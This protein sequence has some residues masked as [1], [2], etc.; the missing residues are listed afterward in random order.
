MI[1]WMKRI[2]AYFTR[3]ELHIGTRISNIVLLL[4]GIVII[5]CIV[6][7]V[8][9]KTSTDGIVAEII[10]LFTIPFL[11]WYINSKRRGQFPIA[12]AMLCLNAIIFPMLFFACGGRTTGMLFWMLLGAL[13]SAF[14]LTGWY[15]IAA[16]IINSIVIIVCLAYQY[17]CPEK[18]AFIESG[19][20][21]L[22]IVAAYC[23]V[24]II[25][26]FA[27]NVQT[28]V[29]DKQ[30]KLLEEKEAELE[31]L[32][33]ELE[34]VSRAKSD[35]LA[36]MSH[37]IRT[38]INAVLGMDEMIIRDAIDPVVLNYAKDIDVAGKQLLSVINDILD[39]SKIEAGK[40]DVVPAEYSIAN[41]VSDCIKIQQ[42]RATDKKLEIK[43]D[44]DADI[45]KTLLGDENR[46]KQ[47]L[48]NIISNAIKY[49]HKGYVKLIVGYEDEPDGDILLKCSVEDSGIGISDEKKPFVFSDYA[50]LENNKN[51]EGTGL[52]LAISKKLVELMGGSI[53]FDSVY[54]TGSTFYF[55]IPQKVLDR[56]PCG[57]F[58][59][60]NSKTHSGKKAYRQSFTAENANVLVVDDV[61]VNLNV[62][63]LL[64][65][66]TKMKIDL[67]ESGAEAL[68]YLGRNH[69]DVVL[70]DHIMPDM[71]GVETLNRI[72]ELDSDNR[73][74]PVI[75]LT[76]N[77]LTGADTFYY[78]AGFCA[79]LTKPVKVNELEKS[80]LKHLPAELVDITQKP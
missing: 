61:L 76:A 2:F 6:L 51:I 28:K 10:L 65:R 59:L 16:Y 48:L 58:S 25:I 53:G 17:Y 36:N 38:P 52:G 73:N 31:R 62:V 5:P 20:E 15:K 27:F 55:A 78:D 66:D 60:D 42:S 79:Y 41:A 37:E 33:T 56:E 13:F 3:E 69:Y 35:F 18:I 12:M 21:N 45:P 67:A 44:F 70:M 46:V 68:E 50:R 71:D 43:V 34:R 49:T 26:G 4:G 23:A 74:V 14:L 63:R 39:F 54:G 47:V 9:L 64:L 22:D 75:A 29:Y 24:M 30:K 32:N 40:L 19:E 11:L 7:S 72:R 1:S 57:E 80:L 77:A 8:F